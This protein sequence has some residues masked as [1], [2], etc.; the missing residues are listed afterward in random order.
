M[1]LI[2]CVLCV[3]CIYRYLQFITKHVL[4]LVCVVCYADQL[5]DT[6]DR[7]V[8]SRAFLEDEKD[9]VEEVEEDDSG[10]ERE[11]EEIPTTVE[12]EKSKLCFDCYKA[13][14]VFS[15]IYLNCSSFLLPCFPLFCITLVCYIYFFCTILYRPSLYPI[16]FISILSH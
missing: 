14:S 15:N 5:R 2:L 8:D 16:N 9:V 6:S 12:T 13:V 7:R 3:V 11:E 4:N 1:F 10:D